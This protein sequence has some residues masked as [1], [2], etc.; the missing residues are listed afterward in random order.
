[1]QKTHAIAEFKARCSDLGR[2][3]R[4][5]RAVGPRWVSRERQRDTYFNTSHGRLKI[6]ESGGRP[7]LVWYF[8]EDALRSKRSDVILLPLSQVSATKTILARELGVKVV[9]DKVR[10]VYLKQNVRIHLDKVRGLGAFVEIESIGPAKDFP[11]LKRQAEAM[12]QMLGLQ[13][14]DLIRGSYSDLLLA[15]RRRGS[16]PPRRERV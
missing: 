9:I 2:A 10:R 14:R 12:A 11:R 4:L 5:A 6:R 13:R 3:A 1:M 16:Q 15:K 8:R 7:Y